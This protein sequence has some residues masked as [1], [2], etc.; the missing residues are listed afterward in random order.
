MAGRGRERENFDNNR[1]MPCAVSAQLQ[2]LD[3]VV[4]SQVG[5]STEK[6]VGIIEQL[7]AFLGRVRGNEMGFGL[8][9]RDLMRLTGLGCQLDFERLN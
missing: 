6:R 1:S 8:R 7:S 5:F 2:G 3:W 9:G 4:V